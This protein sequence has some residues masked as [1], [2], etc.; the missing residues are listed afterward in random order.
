VK[1][2]LKRHL[3]PTIGIFLIVSLFW[4]LNQNP[5]PNYLGLFCGLIL[6]SFFL[7]LDHL[8]FWFFLKPSLPESHQAQSYFQSRQFKSL[9]SLLESTHKGHTSL[10]FHHYFFQ[11]VLTLTTFFVFTSSPNIFVMA[12][13]LSLNL[14]LL[15]DEYVDLNSQ[16]EHLQKWLFA[17]EKKQLPL[18][19]LKYYLYTFFLIN[20]LFLWFL[21]KYFL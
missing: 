16:P 6:G 5:W 10:I 19:Y 7:D 1:G 9:L 3:L 13:L 11:V 21:I 4:F 8:V 15:I 2:E 20:S 17:R 18:P 14:H 12:F